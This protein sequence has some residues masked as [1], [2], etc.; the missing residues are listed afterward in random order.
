MRSDRVA[1]ARC[2]DRVGALLAAGLP[3]N[4]AWAL[5]LEAHSP[6]ARDS[7]TAIAAG[8]S[9]AAVIS[10]LAPGPA[11]AAWDEIARVWTIAEQTGAPSL[12]VVQAL[13]ASSRDAAA[14]ARSIDVALAG[15]RA[16]ARIVLALPALGL[17][18]GALT[19]TDALGVVVGHP[20]GWASTAIAIGLVVCA[21]R[22]MRALV[23]RATP[24]GR[25]PGV[26]LDAWAV[27]LSGGGSWTRAQEVVDASFP[28]SEWAPGTPDALERAL[29]EETLDLARRAG[30]PAA[31]LLRSAA[32]DRRSDAAAERLEAVERLAVQLLV[33]LGVCILPAFVLVGVVP[34]VLAVF[35]STIAA[36]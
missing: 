4:R 24:V 14:V 25:S 35:S 27:A 23:R 26:L 28:A 29:I 31:G 34:V 33:P 3:A 9:A 15:P 12:P 18:L 30:V 8:E 16:S 32:A 13:A 6:D 5:A 1:V 2:L 10:E 36:F 22:W 20:V 19:G 11:S 7:A 17:L 21:H